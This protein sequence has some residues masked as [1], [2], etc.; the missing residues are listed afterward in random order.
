MQEMSSSSKVRRSIS[1]YNLAGFGVADDF[2]DDRDEEEFEERRQMYETLK[3][4]KDSLD[5]ALKQKLAELKAIC[6]QEAVSVSS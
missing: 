5:L 6:L 3:A 4:R 2:L 1:C